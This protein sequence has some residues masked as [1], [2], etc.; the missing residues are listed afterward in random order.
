VGCGVLRANT[1]R[2][3]A[4]VAVSTFCCS[5]E[6]RIPSSRLKSTDARELARSMPSLKAWVAGLASM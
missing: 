2:S 1:L 5:A 3:P 6:R 4:R